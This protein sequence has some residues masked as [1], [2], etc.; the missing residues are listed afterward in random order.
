MSLFDYNPIHK[1]VVQAFP[2]ARWFP[3]K[4]QNHWTIFLSFT[5]HVSLSFSWLLL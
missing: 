3:E 1:C 2:C 4:L 5:K